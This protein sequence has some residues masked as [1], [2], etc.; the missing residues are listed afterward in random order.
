MMGAVSK[1]VTQLGYLCL[2]A[3]QQEAV[4]NFVTGRDVFVSLP[5]GAGKYLCYLVLPIVF[6]CLRTTGRSSI[7]IVV[8]PLKC[9]TRRLIVPRPGG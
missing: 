5:T 9:K 4:V 2:S 3:E 8:S 6:D 1:A 7:V